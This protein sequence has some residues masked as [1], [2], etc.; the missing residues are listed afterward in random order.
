MSRSPSLRLRATTV[1]LASTL[2]LVAA[3]CTGPRP[4]LAA[5]AESTSSTV[6]VPSTTAPASLAEVA[7]ANGDGIDV[8]ADATSDEPAQQITADEATSAPNIPIVFL[9]KSRTRD[10]LEVYLPVPPSGSSGWVRTDDV[11]VSSVPYRIEVALA[12]HRIRVFDRGEVVVDEVVGVGQTDRPTPGGTYYVKELLQPPDPNGTYGTYAYGLSGFS[13]VLSS[14]NGDQ[15]VVGIHGTNDP[16]SIG[17]DV[18]RGCIGLDNAVIAR[19]VDE[20]GLP[21]GTP[22][23]I[24][25]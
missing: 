23:E 19:L 18:P 14:F 21:L 9:V 22:V 3:A 11:I 4:E 7:Q 2:G 20:I 5:T 24:L 8:F 10:R 12:E 15:G 25:E 16:T 17:R 1:A 13:T 6:P